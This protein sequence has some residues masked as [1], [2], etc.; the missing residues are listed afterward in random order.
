MSEASTM[1]PARPTPGAPRP[2]HFPRFQRHTAAN[3]LGVIVAPMRRYP[4]TTVLAMV[5][6]G[7]TS[8]PRGQEGLASLLAGALSEGTA[9]MDALTMADRLE[10]AGSTLD[11][12]SDWDSTVVQ[13]S[14][15]PSRLDDAMAVLAEVL[16]APSFPAADVERLLAERMAQIAQARTDP[17][18]LADRSFEQIAYAPSSRFMLSA[19][20]NR[21]SVG[22]LDR[23]ALVTH[24]ATWFT[25]ATTTVIVVGDIGI[26]EGV[27]LVERHLGGWRGG[28]AA[29]PALDAS[30]R[31]AG[32]T[33]TVVPMAEAAQAELRIGHPSVSRTHPDYFPLSLMNAVLGG[34]FSSRINLNLREAHGWTYGAH[35][36]F[37][38][39]RT[40][41]P[42]S[43]STAVATDVTADAVRETLAE[44]DRIREAPIAADELSLA[45]SFL[46]GVFPIRY[47]T[48]AAVAS[49][50]ANQVIFG[51]PEDYFDTYRSAVRAVTVDAVLRVAREQLAPDRLQIVVAG[52]ADPLL[53]SLGT[54]GLGPVT[55]LPVADLDTD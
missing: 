50:L 8:D 31:H 21:P 23:A 37:D 47:E 38:W 49:A 25:P 54:L 48:T 28:V 15:L 12:G 39:R 24:H 14:A 20:G 41:S 18:A 3:G 36:G 1:A 40:S 35:S 45:V 29:R 10:Q 7:A 46:D 33:I 17:R 26:E 51:L 5:D 16:Q 52:D 13:L 32:R 4:I 55:T 19:G 27:A 6:V 53:Q 2:Y 11:A 43:V 42:F 22:R 30:A 34:L 9:S 44:I